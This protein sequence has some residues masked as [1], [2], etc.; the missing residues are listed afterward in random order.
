MNLNIVKEMKPKDI[1][2]FVPLAQV[3]TTK[4]VKLKRQAKRE[5][6]AVPKKHRIY[7][8]SDAMNVRM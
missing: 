3:S 8:M 2:D 7:Y 4:L 1:N 6:N 5:E